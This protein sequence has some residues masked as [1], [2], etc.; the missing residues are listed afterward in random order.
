M[1]N[2]IIL[3]LL[4]LLASAAAAAAQ[5]TGQP[6][7]N[8]VCAAPNGAAGLP[9]FRPL[10]AADVPA[11]TVTFPVTSVFTRTGA[12]VA[13]A[14]DYSFAQISGSLALGQMPSISANN[15]YGNLGAGAVGL[16]IASC[17][18]ASNALIWTTGSGFGCNTISAG[19][20]AVT[21][22]FT[23]TGAVVAASGDYSFAQVSGNQAL[24][25]MPNAA[26]NTFYGNL[27]ANTPAAVAV[28]A[29]AAGSALGWTAG[30]G[31]ICTAIAAAPVASVFT[32]TGAV[33]AATNDYSFAQISGSL[34]NS[35]LT[36]GHVVAGTG[37]TGGSLAG[38]GTIAADIA[39]AANFRGGTANKLLS[40]DQVFTS[41]VAVT[42]GTTTTFDFSTFINASVTLSGGN[43]TTITF[44]NIKAGQ[45]G[46]LRFIQDSSGGRTIPT[47]VNANLKCAGGCSYTLSTS[48]NAVDVLPYQC[49]STSYCIGGSLLKDVK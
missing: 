22:V 21:S 49:I 10:V 25:Q 1:V 43:I 14:N 48:A 38:G 35:Q 19:G 30:T 34:A 31:F 39:T 44:S 20:G 3:A 7:G 4:I 18:G 15:V 47:T 17:S 27:A 33:V 37:L 2:R 8:T 12:V 24:S 26:A 28:P 46:L 42:Y 11:P 41:E 23:R 36:T 9:T 40:A 5:C 13:A 45:A 16:P 29:C 6:A 32:R